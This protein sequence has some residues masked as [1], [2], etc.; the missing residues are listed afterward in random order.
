[1]TLKNI[2]VSKPNCLR[3][4]TRQGAY[5]VSAVRLSLN[6]RADAETVFNIMQWRAITFTGTILAA[7][8]TLSCAGPQTS[9]KPQPHSEL[10]SIL[11][12]RLTWTGVPYRVKI[13]DEPIRAENAL[14]RFYK[15]RHYAAAWINDQGIGAPAQRLIESIQAAE[16]DGLAPESFHLAA[17]KT[18]IEDLERRKQLKMPL[19]TE[20]LADLEFLLTDAF[21]T[22]GGQLQSGRVKPKVPGY[23]WFIPQTDRKDLNAVLEQ[24]LA[25]DSVAQSLTGL[26]PVSEEYKRLREAYQSYKKLALR[27]GWG[28]VP[29]GPRLKLGD[30]DK[31]VV[32]LRKRLAATQ[33]LVE[34]VPPIDARI[35]DDALTEAIKHFQA[36]HGL[37]PDGVLG[38]GTLSL[39]N[40]SAPKR[41]RQ[42]KVNL[43]RWRW[44]PKELGARYLAVN[45]ADFKLRVVENGASV[46]EM[47]VVVG[48]QYRNTPVFTGSMSYVVLNPRWLVPQKIAVEDLV[49]KIKK[50]PGYLGQNG[51]VVQAKDQSGKWMETDAAAIDWQTIDDENF[52]YRI[53]QG[54][55]PTNALGRVKFMFPNRF[56]VYLHDTSSKEGFKKRV[57]TFSSGCIRVERPLDLLAYVLPGKDVKPE[58][59]SGTETKI[60]LPA[61]LTVHILYQT[62]WVDEQGLVQ[63]R[64]D[65][66]GKDELLDQFL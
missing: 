5:D 45:I 38:A 24:A 57:R 56:N 17:L 19:D 29:P 61:P 49:P 62:A 11:E 39:L 51:F 28:L 40:V 3:K 31:R 42:I 21:L 55:G 65:L 36:R 47:P 2:R 66:Y 27:G 53:E 23:E 35:F 34:T 48:T 32:L 58:F 22:L 44:L 60:M 59:E 8:F 16:G 46:L 1:M 50:D 18:L 13:A 14:P 54:P 43:E 26:L 33:D 15:S 37:K 7:V 63:F 30:R 52:N 4:C 6:F 12:H 9:S 41:L 20:R 25:T 10:K 64:P